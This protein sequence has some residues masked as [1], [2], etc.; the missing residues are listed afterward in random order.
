MGRRTRHLEDLVDVSRRGL[1]GVRGLRVLVTGHT[2]FKGAWLCEWLVRAGA[3]VSGIS[4]PPESPDVL[5]SQ[6]DLGRRLD[7]YECDIREPEAL[8]AAVHRADPELV[9]HLAAQSLVRR[10]YREPLLTWLTNVNGTLNVLE[11]LRML[12]HPVTVVAVTTDKVYRN[13]EW[14]FAYREDDELG[15]HDPYSASKAACELAVASWRACFGSP[16]GVTVI[17]ARAGNVIGPGDVSEDR[18]VPDCFRAWLAGDEVQIRQPGSTRPWQHVLEPLYG[19]LM[20]AAYSRAGVQPAIHACNF[21][22]PADGTRTVAELVRALAAHDPSRRWS[23]TTAPPQHEARALSLSIDR[24]RHVLGW[25]PRLTFDDTVG[26]TNDG[27]VAR[28]GALAKVVAHQIESFEARGPLTS[29]LNIP[30][31]KVETA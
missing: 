21:G 13:R 4:L 3:H 16:D 22:P 8:A 26:W 12:G 31:P 6:L 18:I 7:H 29:P 23:V 2:G 28:D 9:F 30:Y 11:A 15:G 1:L 17:T 27:Y 25:S 19:Y 14:E 20:L 24:A 10:S 5:F